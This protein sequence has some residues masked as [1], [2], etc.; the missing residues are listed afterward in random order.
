MSDNLESKPKAQKSK[1]KAQEAEPSGV[2]PGT[3][4]PF[5]HDFSTASLFQAG[6]QKDVLY[7]LRSQLPQE[8]PKREADKKWRRGRIWH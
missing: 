2:K 5:L 6:V 3:R 4:G 7:S 8:A 1:P